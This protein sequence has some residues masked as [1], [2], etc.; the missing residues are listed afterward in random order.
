MR[1]EP[2]AVADRV[3]TLRI[4]SRVRY[5]RSATRSRF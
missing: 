5:T 2:G 1:S 4:W 3:S